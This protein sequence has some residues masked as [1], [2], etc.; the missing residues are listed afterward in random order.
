MRQL[1]FGSLFLL[2]FTTFA[3]DN[4]FECNSDDGQK[5][6]FLDLNNDTKM[7]A[8][9]VNENAGS[10]VSDHVLFSGKD[11]AISDEALNQLRN[12]SLI[13]LKVLS[14]FLCKFFRV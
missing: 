11:L 14:N 1:L 6:F 2:S 3:V 4:H 9:S 13:Y 12:E 10:E 7:V 8:I 5:V